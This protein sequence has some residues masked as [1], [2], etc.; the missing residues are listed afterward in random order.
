MVAAGDCAA[1]ALDAT[2][3]G[4]R[5]A[6]GSRGCVCDAGGHAI[7]KGRGRIWLA[8]GG[9]ETLREPLRAA[10]RLGPLSGVR[11]VYRVM[12]GRR[13]PEPPICARLFDRVPGADVLFRAVR[14]DGVC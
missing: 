3:R 13:R 5:L 12:G 8:C 2:D 11:S 9:V 6:T 7:G 4:S 14:V 10:G 1:L